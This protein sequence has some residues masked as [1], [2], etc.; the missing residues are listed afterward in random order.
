MF[1]T[2]EII[3]VMMNILFTEDRNQ[4]LLM[5]FVL[6]PCPNNIN[7]LHSRQ[8]QTANKRQDQTYPKFIKQ[9]LA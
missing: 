9:S 7:D 8:N 2:N 1:A 5:I 6:S 3:I 4:I